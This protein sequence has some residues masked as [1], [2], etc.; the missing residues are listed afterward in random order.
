MP[1]SESLGYLTLAQLSDVF[2]GKVMLSAYM[3]AAMGCI[4]VMATVDS[5]P[6]IIYA[7]ICMALGKGMTW[8]AVEGLIPS[9]LPTW[10]WEVGLMMVACASRLGHAMTGVLIGSLLHFLNWNISL[11]VVATFILLVALTFSM[12]MNLHDHR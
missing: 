12:L 10:R 9:Y 11:Y 6:A 8:P 3:F 7:N 4:L 1:I 2:G 5:P